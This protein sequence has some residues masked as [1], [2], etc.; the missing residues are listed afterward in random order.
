MANKSIH[1]SIS[2]DNNWTHLLPDAVARGQ[3]SETDAQLIKSYLTW[4]MS[5]GGI[6][7]K[8]QTKL[9]YSITSFRRYCDCEFS[10]LDEDSFRAAIIGVRMHDYAD[11]TKSDIIGQSKA[12]CK[13]ACSR[14]HLPGLSRQVIDAVKTPKA[15]KVTKTP[16][17]LPTI[18]DVYKLLQHPYC[19]I[20][21]QALIATAF[22]SGARISELL[23][24]NWSD[25]I[26]SSR[27][28]T[29]RIRDTK[30]RKLR[31]VP[32]AEP[33]PYLAAWRRQYPVEDAGLPEGDNP[34][35]ITTVPK[36]GK[37]EYKRAEY[38]AVYRIITR[39][40]K[41]AGVKHCTWHSFRAANITNCT[42][43]RVPESVIKAIHW[44]NQS[45]QMMA[46]YTLLSDETVER[47]MLKRAG[48]E[49]EDERVQHIPQNCPSCCALNGPGDQYC[50]M[51]GHPLSRQAVD[52]Q[53]ALDEAVSYVQENYSVDEMV[54][55]M[56]SVLGISEDAA[57]K[58]LTGGI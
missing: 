44:G 13:W 21:T 17:E 11:W 51:C 20:Q 22:W 7:G 27:G 9:Y 54:H 1:P 56:A 28:V 53:R 43:A 19:R 18:D 14:G 2:K 46:T 55:N 36:T 12:F 49:V 52:K 16:A 10:A 31:S 40:E 38:P 58:L 42:L 26:F 41:A 25:I 37:R 30:T 50:R 24:L 57:R 48:V 15:P 8:R 45:S 33:L 4:K 47:E 23:R 3:M 32:C 35:F 34:V 6:S 5:D 39:L 29:L